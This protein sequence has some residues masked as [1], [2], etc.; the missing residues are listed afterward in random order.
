[1]SNIRDEQSV[2]GMTWHMPNL[3]MMIKWW[4]M[5]LELERDSGIK[6][7][8]VH[9]ILHNELHQCKIALLWVPHALTEIKRWVGYVICS[10]HL[11]CWQQ[12][13][14]RFLS[15]IIAI[16]EFWARA[17]D[18]ELKRQSAEW[19]HAGSPKSQNPSPVKLMVIVAY[20][21]RGIIIWHFVSHGKTVTA[22]YYRDFLVQ[23][24]WRVIW[25]KWRN[26]VD[27]AKILQDN[28]RPHKAECVWQLLRCWGWVE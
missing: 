24:V 19:R 23:Q 16:N 14:D 18:P 9:R 11:A 21:I 6:R 1:M 17:F 7:C 20:D 22:Q 28:A 2:C 15:W 4:L 26:L 13:G 3:W 12:D 5:L 10:D 8:I 27:S 25:D